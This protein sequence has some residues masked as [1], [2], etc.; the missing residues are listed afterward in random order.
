MAT[1]HAIIILEAA[2]LAFLLLHVGLLFR[3]QWYGNLRGWWLKVFPP[4]DYYR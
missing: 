4:V 2:V 3:D 1:V